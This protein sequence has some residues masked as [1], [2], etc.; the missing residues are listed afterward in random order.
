MS[1]SW[2]TG[3]KYIK[4]KRVRICD[5]GTSSL[6]AVVGFQVLLDQLSELGD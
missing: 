1:T 2:F 4:P 6:S 3:E 5:T